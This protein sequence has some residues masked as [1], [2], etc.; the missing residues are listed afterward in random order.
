M[1]KLKDLE[2]KLA[3]LQKDNADIGA[4]SAYGEVTQGLLDEIRAIQDVSSS[5]EVNKLRQQLRELE[6][7]ISSYLQSNEKYDKNADNPTVQKLAQKASQSFLDGN[8]DLSVSLYQEAIG[9]DKQNKELYRSLAIVYLN[10]NEFD[11]A[12]SADENAIKLDDN[13][14]LAWIGKIVA[15]SCRG[16]LPEVVSNF[17][18]VKSRGFP[19]LAKTRESR[20][21]L[22]YVAR[23]HFNDGDNSEAK[24]YFGLMDPFNW[25]SENDGYMET[26][27]T[28]AMNM[29]KNIS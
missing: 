28:S 7:K 18:I 23:A 20:E 5:E 22:F 9:I 4:Y 8:L 27:R 16:N 26:I 17:E 21:L 10:K 29:L 25:T 2:R 1:S 19:W 3:E 13:F 11:N 15:Y 12:I 24:K 6:R 14:F